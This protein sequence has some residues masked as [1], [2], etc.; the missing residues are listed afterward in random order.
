MDILH[1]HPEIALV[2]ITGHDIG[3]FGERPFRELDPIFD[4]QAP[5]EI[6]LDAREVNSASIE[7]SGQWARWM[8]SRRSQIYRF[9][10][11]CGSNFVELTAGF[12]QRFTEFGRQMRIYTDA[13]AFES[14]LA[15]ALGK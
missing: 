14:A 3:E 15:V 4:S 13:S 12:V 1:P 8:M 9:N 5:V 2:R 6:F 11:L 7:V 10:I